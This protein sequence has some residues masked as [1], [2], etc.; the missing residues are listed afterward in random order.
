MWGGSQLEAWVGA[1]LGFHLVMSISSH[2][3]GFKSLANPHPRQVERDRMVR[4][5]IIARGVTDSQVIQAC[6][7]VP[8]HEF[9]PE[10]ER[11][12]AYE[13]H[14][15]PI[16]FGQT[17]SQPYIVAFMTK[18]LGL[19]PHERV[20]EIG[21]GSGYQAAI[22]SQLVDKVFSIEIVE[23]LA[24][25]SKNTLT[26]LGLINVAV[27]AGD[28]YKGWPDEEPFDAI[29][30]TAAP[31]HIP[32]PLLDQLAIGGRLILPLGK[33]VQKLML[34]RRTPEGWRRE[35]LIPVSFVPMTGRA[36]SGPPSLP[37]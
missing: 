21:T 17:I 5:Q 37:E 4:E 15:L 24:E 6:R 14:P 19:Q 36:E 7:E 10:S 9:V 8:R 33:I 23:P 1:L 30:L 12:Q 16:G 29:I 18:A 26:K 22:L 11:K 3:M 28:G 2:G 13:D 35:E 34:I 25:R 27:R 32:L 31:E 20:L